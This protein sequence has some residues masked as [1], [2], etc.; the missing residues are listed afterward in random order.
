MFIFQVY[1]ILYPSTAHPDLMKLAALGGGRAY[2]VPEGEENL[3]SPFDVHDRN[4]I[5]CHQR[6]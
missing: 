5:G 3:V 2:A 6:I 1:P 4:I